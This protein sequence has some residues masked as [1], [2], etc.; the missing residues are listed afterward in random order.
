MPRADEDPRSIKAALSWAKWVL[1]VEDEQ[2]KEEEE[3]LKFQDAEGA[4]PSEIR[5]S[6]AGT[7]INNIPIPARPMISVATLDE[8]IALQQSYERTATLS[9]RIH[10]LTA[11]ATDA[12]AKIIAGIYRAIERDS[13]AQLARRWAYDRTLWCGRGA[14]RVDCEYDTE[15]GHPLDQKIVIRRILY[16]SHC[17]LRSDRG[18]TGLVRWAADDG[19][20]RPAGS[21]LFAPVWQVETG[22]GRDR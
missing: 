16:Q 21:G 13:R 4:W 14:W 1:G 17:A 12:T 20:V 6:R 2:R 15:G 10:A 19:A 7:T 22:A 3:A 11:D 18:G 5:E 8:P 9:P